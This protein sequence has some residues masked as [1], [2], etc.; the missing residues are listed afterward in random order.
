[1]TE[2]SMNV[3]TAA[4]TSGS[5]ARFPGLFKESNGIHAGF[6]YQRGVPVARAALRPGDL[7]FFAEPGR[8]VFHVGVSLGGLSL[9][10]RSSKYGVTMSSLDEGYYARRYCGARRVSRR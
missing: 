4:T 9:S 10:T 5:G 2:E 6:R 8:G 7:V 1:M 3:S